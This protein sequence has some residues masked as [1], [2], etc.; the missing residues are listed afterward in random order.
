MGEVEAKVA[1]RSSDW[2][3]DGKFTDV[4]SFMV[5]SFARDEDRIKRLTILPK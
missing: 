4:P 1:A 3:G 5:M 2:F